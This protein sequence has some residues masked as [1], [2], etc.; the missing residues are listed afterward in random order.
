VVEQITSVEGKEVNMLTL[1]RHNDKWTRIIHVTY[2]LNE[3]PMEKHV[4]YK[5]PW[6][7]DRVAK[8]EISFKY[9]ETERYEQHLTYFG[10]YQI[11]QSITVNMDTARTIEPYIAGAHMKEELEHD[12]HVPPLVHGTICEG[13]TPTQ[14]TNEHLKR[15][16]EQEIT[17]IVEDRQQSTN[18]M[19]TGIDEE[20]GGTYAYCKG[21]PCVWVSNKEGMLPFDDSEHGGLTGDDLPL[22]NKRRKGI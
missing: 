10:T 22:P 2:N 13:F 14:K 7:L 18:V 9:M 17:R 8:A 5:F 16:M 20:E 4:T 1:K 6:D 12:F 11:G 3:T 19:A 15:L 21:L